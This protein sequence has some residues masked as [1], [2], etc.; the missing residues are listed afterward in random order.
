MKE[1][2]QDART[3]FSTSIQTHANANISLAGVRWIILSPKL[4]GSWSSGAI[5]L[6]APPRHEVCVP[7]VASTNP[8]KPKSVRRA[9]LVSSIRMFVWSSQAKR[10]RQRKVQNKTPPHVDHRE[11][12]CGNEDIRH[13]VQLQ[14]A[15]SLMCTMFMS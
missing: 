9:F 4:S 1:P 8:T 14:I 15:A 11:L 3:S 12:I 2:Q 7:A 6:T 5:H 10:N 13:P